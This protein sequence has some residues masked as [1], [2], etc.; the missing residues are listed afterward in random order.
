MEPPWFF[1]WQL[2]ALDTGPPGGP[3]CIGVNRWGSGCPPGW[4]V[5]CLLSYCSCCHQGM[6]HSPWP[7]RH[8]HKNERIAFSLGFCHL[9]QPGGRGEWEGKWGNSLYPPGGSTTKHTL[10]SLDTALTAVL[11][12]QVSM[13]CGFHYHEWFFPLSVSPGR[14]DVTPLHWGFGYFEV[15]LH[16]DSEWNLSNL[17]LFTTENGALQFPTSR[18]PA[19]LVAWQLQTLEALGIQAN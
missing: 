13:G 15:W 19:W 12:L 11:H 9:G 4:S 5:S 16:S 8:M 7:V 1:G 14:R 17:K 10:E 18:Y 2:L 6:C 3:A